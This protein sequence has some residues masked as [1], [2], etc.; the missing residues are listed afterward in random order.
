MRRPCSAGSSRS[1]S[2]KSCDGSL[3]GTIGND[4]PVPDAPPITYGPRIRARCTRFHPTSWIVRAMRVTRTRPSLTR[5]W[6]RQAHDRPRSDGSSIPLDQEM[7]SDSPDGRAH[8]TVEGHWNVCA[9]FL[10]NDVCSRGTIWCGQKV[11]KCIPHSLP[12]RE[13]TDRDWSKSQPHEESNAGSMPF[14]PRRNDSAGSGRAGGGGRIKRTRS[15]WT[16]LT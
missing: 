4:L 9:H 8:V 5:V 6:R 7:G 3:P 11:K 15:R 10:S 2:V 12:R 16:T 14:W 13:G 1:R